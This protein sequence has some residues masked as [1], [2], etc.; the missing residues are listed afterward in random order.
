[1]TPTFRSAK[2]WLAAGALSLA[3]AAPA[4]AQQSDPKWD[5]WLQKSQL[6]PY[7]KNE[8]W[9]EVVANA[10]KEGEVVI[11]VRKKGEKTG[12]EKTFK[13]VSKDVKVSVMKKKEK[14][15]SSVSD[16]TKAISDSKGGKGVFGS[17]VTKGEGDKE[18]VVEIN[19]GAGKRGK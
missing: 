13:K 14:T 16:I 10:K 17:V 9:D 11:T 15:D 2:A 12:D 3:L 1:M 5:A 7:Q 18:E 4:L 6:G 19:Y 8:K